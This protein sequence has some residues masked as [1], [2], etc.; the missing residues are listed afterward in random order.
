MVNRG[1]RVMEHRI[2]KTIAEVTEA[3]A[4]PRSAGSRR[5]C[6]DPVQDD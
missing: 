4:A 3:P 6:S 5:R 1:L 2:R